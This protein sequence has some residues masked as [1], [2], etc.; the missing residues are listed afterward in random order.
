MKLNRIL[1]LTVFVCGMASP[2]IADKMSV[3]ESVQKMQDKLNL[4]EEQADQIRPVLEEYN[5]GMK[6][7]KQEKKENLS[8]ILSGEQMDELKKMEKEEYSDKEKD[9]L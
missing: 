3:D 5:D 4:S 8:G 6:E 9:F 2:A 1:I 7:L